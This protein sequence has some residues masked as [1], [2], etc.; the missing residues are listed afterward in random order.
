[1]HRII[2]MVVQETIREIDPIHTAFTPYL[3]ATAI[4]HSA[5]LLEIT[6]EGEPVF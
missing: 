3:Q 4:L 5:V 2:Y 6:G 1:M